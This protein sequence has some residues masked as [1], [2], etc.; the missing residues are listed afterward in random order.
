MLR[1]GRFVNL[2]WDKLATEHQKYWDILPKRYRLCC[3]PISKPD[4]LDNLAKQC[5]QLCSDYLFKMD[6][7]CG[8]YT[9]LVEAGEW[10]ARRMIYGALGYNVERTGQEY[11]AHCLTP[12]LCDHLIVTFAYRFFCDNL[13][14]LSR[15]ECLKKGFERIRHFRQDSVN[16]TPDA[17]ELNVLRQNFAKAKGTIW[18]DYEKS[19]ESIIDR[20][21]AEQSEIKS[22]SVELMKERTLADQ[23]LPPNWLFTLAMACCWKNSPYKLSQVSKKYAPNQL[24]ALTKFVQNEHWMPVLFRTQENSGRNLHRICGDYYRNQ[25]EEEAAQAEAEKTCSTLLLRFDNTG[26]SFVGIP[27]QAGYLQTSKEP[28]S[29][30]YFFKNTQNKIE[31]SKELQYVFNNYIL[32]R[33]FHFFTLSTALDR[34]QNPEHSQHR[35]ERYAQL[36]QIV[37]LHAPLVHVA[38]STIMA[39]EFWKVPDERAA[40]LISSFIDNW[41]STALPVLEELFL[42]GVYHFFEFEEIASKIENSIWVTDEYGR[43]RYDRLNL[44]RVIPQK[45]K[46]NHYEHIPS[47]FLASADKL[48]ESAYLAG[49]GGVYTGSRLTYDL[50]IC[51]AFD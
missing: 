31:I 7:P 13:E 26:T 1:N 50:G 45:D 21:F 24:I 15:K 42:W 5:I 14:P 43:C 3:C 32:E 39:P 35:C 20:Y 19:L 16:T 36:L 30:T 22:K 46:D 33:N 28:I 17:T 47:A 38:L 37:R 25:Q 51:T 8:E 23:F 44:F 4:S 2:Q 12:A 27:F 48:I 18:R 9:D 34:L 49:I 29:Q 40:A 6:G 11:F 41:N 10:D